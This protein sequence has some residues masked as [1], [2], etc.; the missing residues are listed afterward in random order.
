MCRMSGLCPLWKVFVAPVICSSQFEHIVLLDICP[1]LNSP[2]IMSKWMIRIYQ[3]PRV[4]E[5]N[6][7][8]CVQ[9]FWI[10]INSNPLSAFFS[11]IN[12]F[13]K[14]NSIF[15]WIYLL[16]IVYVYLSDTNRMQLFDIYIYL[17][18]VRHSSS[19][20]IYNSLKTNQPYILVIISHPSMNVNQ[21]NVYCQVVW[22]LQGMFIGVC[23][24]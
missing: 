23:M 6:P 22:N 14:C 21:N 10:C 4:F 1:S 11:S 9:P 24:K 7:N 8:H 13:C 20:I 19:G 16:I 3:P 5:L 17:M 2:S 12:H 15:I 18:N